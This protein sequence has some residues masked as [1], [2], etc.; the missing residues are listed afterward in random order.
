MPKLKKSIL[1]IV[2][3]SMLTLVFTACDN[4]ESSIDNQA[5]K[6]EIGNRKI[7]KI[8]ESQ[9]L[10]ASFVKGR[11]VVDTLSAQKNDQRHTNE[12][13]TLDKQYR[14]G[15]MQPL[16]EVLQQ[17]N[18]AEIKKVIA[19]DLTSATTRKPEKEIFEA[20]QYN[21]AQ[22]LKVD[23]NVQI[24]DRYVF[25]S[26][27]ILDSGELKGMWSIYFDKSEIVKTIR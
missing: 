6:E 22:G 3:L 7:K 17:V 24:L 21:V 19:G 26:S 4:T 20:Y 14:L 8:S 18:K 5:I 23:D 9:I 12:S 15:A 11:E 27:P 2:F 16:V 13:D 25:Y 1:L 10:E